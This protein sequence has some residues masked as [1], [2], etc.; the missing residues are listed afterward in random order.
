MVS[1]VAVAAG[2]PGTLMLDE[3]G[4][5]SIWRNH[6]LHFVVGIKDK[7]VQIAAGRNHGAILTEKGEVLIGNFFDLMSLQGS[8][9]VASDWLEAKRG[10]RGKVCQVGCQQESTVALTKEGKVWEWNEPASM[11]GNHEGDYSISVRRVKQVGEDIVQIA[12]GGWHSLCLDKNGIVWRWGNNKEGQTEPEVA[13]QI[14]GRVV[15]VAAGRWHSLALT[16]R[17]EV[18][19][20]GSNLFGQLGRT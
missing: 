20:W 19:T 17:G 4:R 12:V 15:Q 1:L 8:M 3:L 6:K 16:D 7:V 9:V 10:I 5:I 13:E 2:D 14:A 18:W 11:L